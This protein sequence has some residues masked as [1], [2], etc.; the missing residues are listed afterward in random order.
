MRPQLHLHSL[1]FASLLLRSL[2]HHQIYEIHYTYTLV[3]PV[4]EF[5]A[6]IVGAHHG[7]IH[8][9]CLNHQI[10]SIEDYSGIQKPKVKIFMANHRETK[11]IVLDSAEPSKTT[12]VGMTMDP[13]QEHL[14]VDFFRTYS[15][16]FAWKPSNTPR[17]PQVVIEDRLNIRPGY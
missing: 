17:I 9:S 4:R 10:M 2:C 15:N 5:R 3:Y 6:S 8:R 7:V 1:T 12:R 13:D 16:V 14:V 11:A